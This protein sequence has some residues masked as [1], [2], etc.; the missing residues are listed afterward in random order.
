MQLHFINII[1]LVVI[2]LAAMAGIIW[3]QI[4]LCRK[5][6]RWL[7]LILPAISFVLSWLPSLGIMDTGDTWQNILLIVV[8][9]LLSNVP[10]VALLIIYFVIRDR[11]KKK[12]QLS[13]MNIQDLN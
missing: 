8:S 2:S 11:I 10:T 5:T 6:S 9:L 12:A 1:L 13:K 7:G 4:V 3:L